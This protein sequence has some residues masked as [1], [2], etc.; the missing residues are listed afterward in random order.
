MKF[1]IA[2]FLPVSPPILKHQEKQTLSA[3][4]TAFH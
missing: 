3:N 2:L 1:S 4:N